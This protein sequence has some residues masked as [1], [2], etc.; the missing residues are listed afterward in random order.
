MQRKATGNLI[1]AAAYAKLRG[2]S[3]S[4]VSRQ[5]RAGQIPTRNGLLDP[6][7]ADTAREKNLDPARRAGAELRKRNRPPERREADP[8]EGDSSGREVRI[9]ALAEVTAVREVLAFAGDCVRMGM[10]K[11][12]ACAAA[13]LYSIHAGEA[14]PDIECDDYDDRFVDPTPDD[15]R[16]LFGDFD[17]AAADALVEAVIQMD[18]RG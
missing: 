5:V 7:A 16:R 11:V 17:I 9:D 8:H 6:I 14:M 3:R 4:T 12:Q 13:Q 2:L 15:W 18:G 10:S 1:T